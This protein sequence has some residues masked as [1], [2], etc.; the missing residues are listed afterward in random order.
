ML[1][2][3]LLDRL[4]LQ[5]SHLFRDAQMLPGAIRA[6]CLVVDAA[7]EEV[8]LIALGVDLDRTSNGVFR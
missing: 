8:R 4:L 3:A 1:A 2:A 6:A 5:P 7:L